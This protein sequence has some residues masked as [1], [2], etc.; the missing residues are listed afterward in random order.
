MAK[1]GL[2][3]WFLQPEW[4]AGY[5]YAFCFCTSFVN[6]SASRSSL[7]GRRPRRCNS[8]RHSE[9]TNRSW[10]FVVTYGDISPE[11]QSP[12]ARPQTSNLR[13]EPDV[14]SLSFA[15][16]CPDPATSTTTWDAKMLKLLERS[17]PTGYAIPAPKGTGVCRTK[18]VDKVWYGFSMPSDD[19]KTRSK[20]FG[21]CTLAR[22]P[23]PVLKLR[24][25][26][27]RCSRE[28]L[29]TGTEWTILPRW[30]SLENEL[31]Q[32]EGTGHQ[33]RET[34]VQQQRAQEASKEMRLRSEKYPVHYS[35]VKMKTRTGFSWLT[36]WK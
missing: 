4:T 14:R 2:K 11:C 21:S 20:Q 36:A 29:R 27:S 25:R 5:M 19:E 26:R 15:P 30:S 3:P 22:P 23:F 16:P 24:S 13:R 8:S 32:L 9:F 6:A 31:K 33:K 10:S 35:V 12:W 17:T 28:D 18:P 1:A 34:E 7:T